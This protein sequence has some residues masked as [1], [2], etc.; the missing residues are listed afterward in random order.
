MFGATKLL[1][2]P[3]FPILGVKFGKEITRASGGLITGKP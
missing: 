3:G 1:K 2:V